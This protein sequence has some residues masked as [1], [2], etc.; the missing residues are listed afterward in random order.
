MRAL[1]FLA[2]GG[3]SAGALT[4]ILAGVAFSTG[5]AVQNHGATAM[6][7]DRMAREVQVACSGA[8][9]VDTTPGCTDLASVVAPQPAFETIAHTSGS[10]TTLMR[11]PLSN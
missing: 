5:D 6:K 7:S 1:A 10:V 4:L 11:R 2:F 3:A 9:M 8:T